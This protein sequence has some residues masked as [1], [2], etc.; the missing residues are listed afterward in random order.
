MVH[1]CVLRRS[2]S[3]IWGSFHGGS[4]KSTSKISRFDGVSHGPRAIRAKYYRHFAAEKDVPLLAART[5]KSGRSWRPIGLG[6]RKNSWVFSPTFLA[7][8]EN[9][10]RCIPPGSLN[11]PMAGLALY[12]LG[13]ARSVSSAQACV[14]SIDVCIHRSR[15]EWDS[16]ECG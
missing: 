7:R 15:M 4:Q 3:P 12:L 1:G 10:N 16:G 5:E 6:I 11:Q 13:H 14:R 8:A 2:E 9:Q